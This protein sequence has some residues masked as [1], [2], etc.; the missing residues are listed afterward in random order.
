MTGEEWREVYFSA[1]PHNF[2]ELV[3]LGKVNLISINCPLAGAKLQKW[4]SFRVSHQWGQNMQI[5]K[6][7]TAQ[8]TCPNNGH[9]ELEI[10][11]MLIVL[12]HENVL[13]ASF[14]IGDAFH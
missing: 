10:H 11:P 12:S 9:M 4:V 3:H 8:G 6:L 5:G 2:T 14:S 1:F 7:F 13:A